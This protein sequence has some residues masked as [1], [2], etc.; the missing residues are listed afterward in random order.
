[1]RPL[2]LGTRARALAW[3]VVLENPLPMVCDYPAAYAGQ[4]GFD[5]LVEV[6]TTWDESR[7]LSAAIGE[8]IAWVRRKGERW[9]LGAITDWTPRALEL[10]LEFLGPGKH[11]LRLLVDPADP[12]SDPN[13]L[14]ESRRQVTSE[15]T[16]HLSLAAGGGAVAVFD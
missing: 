15:D 1:M 10:S 12:D 9:Y 4:P 8:H 11:E 16:L 2:V 5:F 7:V 14:V 3:Y 6:P 13:V